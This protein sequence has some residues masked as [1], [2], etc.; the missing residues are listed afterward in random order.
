MNEYRAR[1]LFSPT[2]FAIYRQASRTGR[3]SS[4]NAVPKK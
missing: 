2:Q 1:E 3:F 4:E